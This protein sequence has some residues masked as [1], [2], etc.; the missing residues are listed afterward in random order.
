MPEW[1][2]REGIL[3]ELGVSD[4]KC[5]QFKAKESRRKCHGSQYGKDIHGLFVGCFFSANVKGGM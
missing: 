3:T 5:H 1:N 2:L 4:D